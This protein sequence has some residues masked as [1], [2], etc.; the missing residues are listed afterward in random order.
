MYTTYKTIFTTYIYITQYDMQNI[1]KTINTTCNIH[2]T[3]FAT[4]DI[5]NTIFIAHTI[6]DTKYNT[7]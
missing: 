5:S 1:H 4:H 7:K 2:N 3:I 6:H